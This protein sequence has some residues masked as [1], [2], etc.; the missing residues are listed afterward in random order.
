[1]IQWNIKDWQRDSEREF[2]LLMTP[3][4]TK[5]M[6]NFIVRLTSCILCNVH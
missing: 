2:N 1:M 6:Y 4:R 3:M 5:N